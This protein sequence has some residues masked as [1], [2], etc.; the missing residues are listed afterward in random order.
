MKMVAAAKLRKAQEMA[1][2]GR[3][4][5]DKMDLIIQNLSKAINDPSNAPKLLVGT[6]DGLYSYLITQSEI[7]L[8]YKKLNKNIEAIGES[9]GE[10]WVSAENDLY[11]IKNDKLIHQ[12]TNLDKVKALTFTEENVL[13][14]ATFG[15]GLYQLDPYGFVNYTNFGSR[16]DLHIRKSIRFN[17]DLLSATKSGLFSKRQNRFLLDRDIFDFAVEKDKTLWVT[18]NRGLYSYDGTTIK[19]VL[20]DDINPDI[21]IISLYL[22]KNGR[23][24]LG[25]MK[26][27]IKYDTRQGKE[28]VF[29][30]NTAD[31][32]ISN[33]TYD[34]CF[35]F[36]T[37]KNTCPF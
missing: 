33:I 19:K 30:Y 2:K 1:E 37:S 28:E 27:L 26:G 16:K 10:I 18:T 35:T 17:G 13:L 23:K 8:N 5:S 11:K 9:R 34:I 12:N 29:L 22:E 25:T 7:K 21:P 3:P 20:L 6:G 32:L 31:G 36:S 14:I 24:W 15:D 4:Y